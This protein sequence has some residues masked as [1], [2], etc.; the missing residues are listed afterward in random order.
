MPTFVVTVGVGRLSKDQKASIASVLTTIHNTENG[1]PRWCVQVIFH[2]IPAGNHFIGD[3]IVPADQ[4]WIN[5]DTRPGRTAEKKSTMI[6]RMVK[7]V[8]IASGVDASHIWVYV[9]EISMMA[10]FGM[11]FPPPG[12]EASFVASVVDEVRQRYE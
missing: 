10:E 1:V 8:S 11:L 2:E 4:I 3:K 9:N 12:M 6:S 5:A 7:E